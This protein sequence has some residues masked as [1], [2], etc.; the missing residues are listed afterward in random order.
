MSYH[1]TSSEKLHNEGTNLVCSPYDGIVNNETM[2][3]W[4]QTCTGDRI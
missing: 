1:P 3:Q 2:K 4:P